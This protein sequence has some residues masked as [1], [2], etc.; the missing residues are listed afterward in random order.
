MPPDND[1]YWG[2]WAAHPRQRAHW[3]RAFTEAILHGDDEHKAWLQEAAEAYIAGKPLPP[4]RAKAPILTT[5]QRMALTTILT[6]Y[7][8]QV[9]QP[10]EF[11]DCSKPDTPTTTVSDLM[12][13]LI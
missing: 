5:S 1:P 8:T 2:E 6:W 10:Q 9:N 13:Q 12:Q 7:C 11:T 4:P 3:I